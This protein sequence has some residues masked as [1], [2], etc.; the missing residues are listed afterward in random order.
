MIQKK[1]N[2]MRRGPLAN[3]I[4]LHD[5]STNST[6][7]KKWV[8]YSVSLIES[9]GLIPNRMGVVAPEI[10]SKS[11]VTFKGGL[12]QLEKINLENLQ[13][14]EIYANP[15]FDEKDN[16]ENI[17]SIHLDLSP[18]KKMNTLIL[19]CDNQL[20][21]FKKNLIN[22]I[23]AELGAFFGPNYGY[24]Y[25]RLFKLGPT[26]YP[27]GT[28]QGL[29]WDK[30]RKER[31]DITKWNNEYRMSDGKYKIGDLRDIYPMNLLSKTH[32]NLKID[33]LPFFEWIKADSKRG[34]LTA[35]NDSL[36]AWWVDPDNI[37]SVRESLRPLGWM[38]AV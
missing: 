26:W 35:L 21:P 37:P 30:D 36:W 3:C 12:K 14:I 1:V 16:R 19:A 27:F 23:T 24:A 22:K 32:Q 25:Q 8:D 15:A 10:T 11:T 5:F 31:E 20:F 18:N 6:D 33:S 38:L 28:I 9:L 34:S 4:V 29:D 2:D 13:G 7:I 17:C